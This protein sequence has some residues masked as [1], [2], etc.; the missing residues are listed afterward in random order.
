M[1]VVRKQRKIPHIIR[2]VEEQINAEAHK[3]NENE[4]YKFIYVLMI[5]QMKDTRLL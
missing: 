3:L 2:F 1:P 5:L 4:I